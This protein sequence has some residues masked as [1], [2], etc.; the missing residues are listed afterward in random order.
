MNE[1]EIRDHYRRVTEA[2][3]PLGAVAGNPTL[4]VNDKVGWYI[5]RANDDPADDETGQYEK[6]RRA[7][8]FPIDY[9]TVVE[10]H[11][12]RT[13]Y[14]LSSYK[15]PQAFERWEA[16]T[17]NDEN[18]QYD[19]KNEKPT[20]QTEDLVAISA[21]GDMDLADDLKAQRPSLDDE[22][23][24]VAEAA[25]DAYIDAF[26]D[27]YGGRD[28]V[29]MLDSVG[30]GYIFGAS[31]AT[32]PI[33]RHFQDDDDARAR[34]FDAFIE[35]SNKYLEAAEKRINDEIERA[36]DVVHPDWANNLNRQYKMPLSLHGDHDCVVTPVDVEDV[37]YREPVGIEAVDESL[38]NDVQ[39]WCESLTAVEYED[40]VAAIVATLWPD[41][42][43]DCED[44]KTALEMWIQAERENERA[45][46][47]RREQAR[48]RREERLEE[49]GGGLEDTLLTP[50]VEDVYNALD[51]LSI[52][53]VAE[54]TIV[55]QWTDADSSKTDNSG[56]GKRA[57][58]PVWRPSSNG[59]A[60]YIDEK[61]IWNDTK[62]G[63]YGS[64]VEAAL[65]GTS[66][67]RP[68]DGTASG[69][70]WIE[71]VDALRELGFE[72]PLW[73]PEAG[74]QR[75][76]GDEYEKMPLW[77]LRKAAVALDVVPDDIFIEK[78]T[79]EGETYFDFP[80]HQSRANAL[81]AVEEAG[82]DHGWDMPTSPGTEN[83]ATTDESSDDLPK[84]NP[85]EFECRGGCYGYTTEETDIDG[86]TWEKWHLGTNFQLETRAFIVEDDGATVTAELTVHPASDESPF[87]VTVPIDVFTEP[88]KFRQNVA[89]GRTTTF[90]LGTTFLNKIRRFVGGQDAPIRTPTRHI[91][92]HGD[93][94]VTPDGV[95]TADGWSENP[96]TVIVG[97]DT[98]V[99]Q[100]WS[101]TPEEGI[102]YDCD[103][104]ADI[105]ETLPQT[106]ENDRFLPVIGWFYAAALRPL[107]MDWT[108]EFNVLNITGDTGAGKTATLGT[109]WEL[110]GMGGEPLSAAGSAF[111]RLTAFSSSNAV[112][113]W[114]DEFKPAEM[115]DYQQDTF[116]SLLRKSTRGGT[117]PKGNADQS[118]DQW[119]LRAPTVVSGEQLVS[120]PA[121]ERRSIQTVFSK[122]VTDETS[123]YYR[124]FA[125]LAGEEYVDDTGEMVYCDGY[126]LADHARAYYSWILNR[127]EDRDTL[128]LA[129][130]RA[131]ERVTDLLAA[132]NITVHPTV[133]QGFQTILFGCRLYREFCETMGADAD[134][135]GVTDE[136]TLDAILTTA[137]T[138]N[139][140]E[141]VSHL[142][143]FLGLA[144]RASAADYLEAGE[145]Y[146]LVVPQ[147]GTETDEELRLKLAT[148]F[149]Q[150]RRYARDHD[151]KD[152][153]LLD[154]AHDYRIRIQD[155]EENDDSVVVSS[156][157][158]T[159]GLNKTSS[160]SVT[161]ATD[162]IDTF[163]RAM[164][165]PDASPDREESDETDDSTE[166]RDIASLSPEDGYV[167][168]EGIAASILDPKPWLDGE[169]T[170]K[171][172]SGHIDYTVRGA[173]ETELEQAS[174]YKITDAKV[175]T[176]DGVTVLELR[177]GMT[178]V[179][180]TGHI[181]GDQSVLETEQTVAD[182]GEDGDRDADHEDST[183]PETDTDAT[184]EPPVDAEGPRAD[185]E[186]I[187]TMINNIG[188]GHMHR[189]H[190]LSKAGHRLDIPPKR[191]EKLIDKALSNG[192][193]IE[194]E[195]DTFE[196]T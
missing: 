37:E 50:L 107:I 157:V 180:A 8:S 128:E 182:G 138:G 35:R 61:G 14:A 29:Y 62:E 39:A 149:D 181:A 136:N 109:L 66:N 68:T 116:M 194:S 112:P 27:L 40:R 137:D 63:T 166:C 134:M 79:D 160:F 48:K 139:G 81:E 58:I 53:T 170:L 78:S 135:A 141:H 64:V 51:R 92:L 179:E 44:W 175:T 59:T 100:K 12:D 97:N 191:T 77:A 33:A 84:P 32:L 36:N 69:R 55:H 93:E 151:V 15:R 144:A 95:L 171:D 26:A 76:D 42:F 156:S 3:E 158:E 172:E 88:R 17:F 177:G 164:F 19:Y 130:H 89:T 46:Q 114:F 119:H 45:E 75:H 184:E 1:R 129:W 38:L 168:V 52:E 104:V 34:V 13:L 56:S 60:C 111:T 98:T 20:P 86:E 121:E 74:S 87:D 152:G 54:Q 70:D 148:S 65:I 11:V 154:S 115:T 106:R 147:D 132:E 43:E 67:R 167:T 9:E 190:L 108:G 113:V 123:N 146:K 24:A 118:E 169:G 49:L 21:W 25:Y 57:F 176:D 124:Q 161:K 155:G 103:E 41:E 102:D 159:Y 18:E 110:F 72:V 105:L 73:L 187:V 47:Q 6:K 71:G 131:G 80:G 174:P 101:L 99:P 133:K 83:G 90:D 28:A 153:D 195:T 173:I 120:G 85:S 126:D 7:R 2:V 145:H 91:G 16:A 186:R 193:L 30:G 185:I 188:G 22:T 82:Y 178:G 142:D 150:I 96:E 189:S 143:R 125:R 31:E 4:L 23:Y 162:H 192:T 196:T 165:D 117:E 127:I 140:H 183:G 5:T 10:D 163:E 122:A 94:W